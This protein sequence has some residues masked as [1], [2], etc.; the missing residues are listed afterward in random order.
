MYSISTGLPGW[1]NARR[2]SC[3]D[4]LLDDHAV[5]GGSY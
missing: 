4:V 2:M 1:M 5:A 3:W